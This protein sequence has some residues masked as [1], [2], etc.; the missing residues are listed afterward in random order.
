MKWFFTI[1]GFLLYKIPGAILGYLLGSFFN[2]FLNPKNKANYIPPNNRAGRYYSHNSVRN[3]FEL[4]LLS[5]CAVVIR[6]DNEVTQAELD[7]VR[8]QFVVFFGKEKANE[9]F[10]QFKELF[11]NRNVSLEHV[12]GL[13]RS[14]TNYETRLQIIHFLFGIAKSDGHISTE[15]LKKIEEIAVYFGIS[16][17]DLMSIK[18]MFLHKDN[19]P[20]LNNAYAILEIEPSATDS[21]VK[22]AYREMAKKY[23]PDKV[24]SDN[25]AIKKGAEEKFKQVQL[26][27]EQIMES[28]RK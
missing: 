22:K 18:A 25:E 16:P 17:I 2:F 8:K 21:E 4:H 26:A 14:Q 3:N 15:E 27:Y 13:L 19:K 12:C 5:L 9:T 7:F 28:R 23:H 24:I 11:K 1:I 6:A 10:R 20:N